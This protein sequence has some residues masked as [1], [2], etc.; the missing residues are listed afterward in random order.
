MRIRKQDSL[1]QLTFMPRLFP[2]N[3]YLIEE[4]N[5]LT[6]VDAALPSSVSSILSAAR[7]IG[8]P[9][10]RI[11]LTHAHSDHIGALDG[12]KAA[13]PDVKV[14]L[15]GMEWDILHNKEKTA[16]GLPIKGSYPKDIRTKPD[17]LLNEGDRVC[18]LEVISSPGHSPGMLA[19]VDRRNG[20]LLAGDAF[21]LRGGMAVSG[22][23]RWRFPFPGWATW[24]KECAIQS[25]RKLADLEPT[26][27]AIGH[28]DLLHSPAAKMNEAILLADKGTRRHA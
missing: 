9:I 13:L 22:D 16:E 5:E 18:S 1:Y 11:V 27:L 21:Q 23:V 20:A 10:T 6:L 17:D 12:L 24:N 26:I 2:V 25:A 8:K 19:F 7:T 4:E 3:C 28:G 14:M 15:S